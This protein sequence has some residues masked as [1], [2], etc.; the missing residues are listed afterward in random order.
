MHSE[1]HYRQL[2]DMLPDAVVVVGECGRIDLANLQAE[3]LFGY[4]RSELVHQPI[5][6]VIPA[7]SRLEHQGGVSRFFA[8]AD[9][10][11]NGAESPLFGCHKNG[12][13]FPIEVS[14]SPLRAAQGLTI[15]VAIRDARQRPPLEAPD[16][17]R[18]DPMASAFESIQAA[19]ALFDN[20][21]RLVF[22][23][24]LYGSLIGL[25]RPLVGTCYEDL[26]GAWMGDIAFRDDTERARF[27]SARKELNLGEEPTKIDVRMRDGRSVR[28]THSRAA[29]GG[30]AMTVWDQTD[31]V[32]VADELRKAYAAAETARIATS[33]YRSSMG[34]DLRTPMNV[35]LGFAQLLQQ[36]RK[37]PLSDRHRDRVA[38]ILRGGEELLRLIEDVV[39]LPVPLPPAA[40]SR[41]H[42]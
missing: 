26:L 30:M 12:T 2:F 39:D 13:L 6:R 5:A 40:A 41:A 16:R 27:R 1:W 14:S 11:P 37:E 24:H 31:C 9:T 33:E 15:S 29:D 23:N 8:T 3:E 25:D 10:A 4:R 22:C 35:I 32:D 21:N 7:W 19:V 34:H 17:L 42:R 36:D 18:A 28:F 38:R 20:E